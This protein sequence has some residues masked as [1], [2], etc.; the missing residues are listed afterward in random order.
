VSDERYQRL[1]EVLDR[2]QIDLTVLLEDIH[3]PHNIA[4]ISRTADAVCLFQLHGIGDKAIMK[5]R[6]KASSGA[7]RWV[8]VNM[9]E[10]TTTGLAE[11]KR[12]GLRIVAADPGEGSVEFTN[13]DFTQ[14]TAIVLGS[15]LTGLS[16]E[17]R[18]Q[19]DD[20]I[21]VPMLG[22]TESLNV[23][24]TAALILYEAKRQREIAGLYECRQLDDETYQRT[25]FEW[26]QPKIAH[27]CREKKL[28]YPEYDLESGEITSVIPG[29]AGQPFS[30]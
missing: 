12:Q 1:R 20:L 23:S 4:A 15:E 9:H 22:F 14:P 30:Q 29:S 11:L 10:D 26:A 13:Y 19:A 6:P 21:H 5:R 24:V 27:Y 16:D 8:K 3:K 28:P 25:L 7:R 18:E 2:R 17:V